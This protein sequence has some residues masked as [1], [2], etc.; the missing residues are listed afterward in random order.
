MRRDRH[1]ALDSFNRPTSYCRVWVSERQ[2]FLTP[3]LARPNRG[4]C[5]MMGMNQATQSLDVD[6]SWVSNGKLHPLIT[7]ARDGCQIRV[8]VALEGGSGKLC[9]VSR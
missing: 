6:E 1:M 7:H 4:D 3:G 5:Q 8:E 9:C 2:T